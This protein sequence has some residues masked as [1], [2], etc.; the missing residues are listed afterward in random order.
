MRLNISANTSTT[1]PQIGGSR[2]PIQ[3]N[4]VSHPSSITGSTIM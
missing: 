4:S 1:S 3:Q 2:W